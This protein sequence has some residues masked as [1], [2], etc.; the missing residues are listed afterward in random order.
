M[1][2]GGR[3]TCRARTRCALQHDNCYV[4]SCYVILC[5]YLFNVWHQVA[6][7]LVGKQRLDGGWG[8]SYLSCQDKV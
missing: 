4:V 7:F 5:Y 3:A 2:A 8:E 1:A 6:F